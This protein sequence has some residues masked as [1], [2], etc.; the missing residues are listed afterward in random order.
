MV[1]KEAATKKQPKEPRDLR[2]RKQHFPEGDKLVFDTNKKGF[3][4]VAIIMRKLLRYLSAPEL[5][6][7]VYLQTRCSRFFV[8]YPTLEEIAHDL[9]LGGRRNLTPHL[10]QLERK[11][12]ISTASG[13]GKKYFLVH[14]PR[15]AIHHLLSTGEIDESGLAEIN[16]VLSDLNQEEIEYKPQ[17]AGALNLNPLRKKQGN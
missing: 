8:C 10:K 15:V 11:Q 13:G 5:R 9:G 2:L 4:P 12:F 3:V 17:K 14:D 6:V 1:A 7:L 16:D